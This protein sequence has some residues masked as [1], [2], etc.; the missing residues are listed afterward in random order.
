[1][2]LYCPLLSLTHFHN[3]PRKEYMNPEMNNDRLPHM[4]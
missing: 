3:V 2:G 1:M 4:P